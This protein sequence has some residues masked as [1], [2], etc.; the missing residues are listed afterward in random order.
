MMMVVVMMMQVLAGNLAIT[1]SAWVYTTIIGT[2]DGAGFNTA[3]LGGTATFTACVFNEF[4]LIAAFNGAGQAFMVA[5]TWPRARL[6]QLNSPKLNGRYITL[7]A[8]YWGALC[9]GRDDHDGLFPQH[10]LGRAH[11][12]RHRD[13]RRLWR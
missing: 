10:L 5:G 6:T 1:S 8:R 7:C 4:N 12:D 3:V 13:L 11:G 9:R 2:E